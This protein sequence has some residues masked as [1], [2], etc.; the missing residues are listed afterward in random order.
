ME[1]A[2]WPG[3]YAGTP[4]LADEIAK[5]V[6]AEFKLKDGDTVS[7]DQI[8]SVLERSDCGSL[9]ATDVAMVLRN[10]FGVTPTFFESSDLVQELE[11]IFEYHETSISDGDFSMAYGVGVDKAFSEADSEL[12][13]VII[14]ALSQEA[15]E[16][17]ANMS[18]MDEHVDMGFIE[19][20]VQVYIAGG[21]ALVESWLT[22]TSRPHLIRFMD[23]SVIDALNDVFNEDISL[24]EKRLSPADRIYRNDLRWKASQAKPQN[25]DPLAG[26]QPDGGMYSKFIQGKDDAAKRVGNWTP[27]GQHGQGWVRN[28]L[29][30]ATDKMNNAKSMPFPADK[31]AEPDQDPSSMSHHGLIRRAISKIGG[32]AGKLKSGASNMAGAA[33]KALWKLN[34]NRDQ[35]AQ[36]SEEPQGIGSRI[37]HGAKRLMKGVGDAFARGTQNT[38]DVLRAKSRTRFP[39]LTYAIHGAPSQGEI[40]YMQRSGDF[41]GAAKNMKTSRMGY[42][43]A[44]RGREDDGDED[45]DPPRRAPRP[46]ARRR[47]LSY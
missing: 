25:A 22:A 39:G 38:R 46:S 15:M 2:I 6:V 11:T 29:A 8:I 23:E 40:D 47:G 16:D 26:K 20:A 36:G 32:I 17:V 10:M 42:Q 9:W 12:D 5:Q 31:P 21:D 41:F 24:V 33:D 13:A 28:Q 45:Y 43:S 4:Y 30:T 18:I 34:P 35:P 44:G 7:K 1:F 19:E 37:V 27:S 3:T 14:A